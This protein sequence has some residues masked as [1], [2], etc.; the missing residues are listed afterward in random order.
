MRESNTEDQCALLSSAV[1]S[2]E[3]EAST[4]KKR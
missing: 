4:E 1:M 3:L 2:I